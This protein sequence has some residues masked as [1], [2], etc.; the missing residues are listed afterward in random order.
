MIIS[1]ERDPY[2]L[3]YINI[4]KEIFKKGYR[5]LNERTNIETLRIPHAIITVDLG[6]EFPILK[7][8]YVNW[9]AAAKEILWIMQKQSNNINDLDSKIWDEWADEDGSIRKAYGYQIAKPVVIDGVQYES[10]IHYILRKLESDSSDRRC[11]VDMWNVDDLGQMNLAPCCFA[12]IW[13]IVDD[14]LNC[15][16]IQRS[17]DFLVGV[18]FN[19]TQYAILTHLLARHL[20]VQVGRLTHV[21]SDCHIYCYDSHLEGGKK[22]IKNY[23]RFDELN[24]LSID[25]LKE[26][27]SHGVEVLDKEIKI[28]ESEPKFII[29]SSD[30]NFFSIS[31]D[32]FFVEDYE[33]VEKI[34]FDVAV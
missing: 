20:G 3:Q 4:L 24:L 34:K 23:E 27:A 2:E 32:D 8:K 1:N 26:L 16:L 14:K 5:Q 10:Q 15:M 25:H 6:L 28:I 9:K 17:A 33:Y 29:D 11:V 18:P 13:N 7:S 19:T 21:M 22:I 12:S 31:I 30:T